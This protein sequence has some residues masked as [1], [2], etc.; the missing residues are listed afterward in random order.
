MQLIVNNQQVYLPE[1]I[2]VRIDF[3][4]PDIT[5]DS[6]PAAYIHWFEF[7]WTK[8]NIATF[9]NANHTY[10]KKN[11]K[12]QCIFRFGSFGFNGYLYL[13]NSFVETGKACITLFDDFI[14]ADKTFINQL[15]LGEYPIGDTPTAVLLHAKTENNK[16]WPNAD[17]CFPM[18]HIAD[19]YGQD[20]KNNLDYLGWINCYDATSQSFVTNLVNGLPTNR[21]ALVPCFYLFSALKKCFEAFGYNTFGEFFNILDFNKIAV[22]NNYALDKYQSNYIVKGEITPP[23]LIQG[24]TTNPETY[25]IL[26]GNTYFDGQWIT[27]PALGRYNISINFDYRFENTRPNQLMSI[28]IF[29]EGHPYYYDCSQFVENSSDTDDWISTSAQIWINVQSSIVGHRICFIYNFEL[30][31]PGD[32]W[33]NTNGYIQNLAFVVTNV[34]M[35]TYNALA[36]SIKMNNHLPAISF[37]ELIN[38]ICKMFFVV[39]FFDFDKKQVEFEVLDNIVDSPNFID[40]TEFYIANNESTEVKDK[41]FSFSIGNNYTKDEIKNVPS[42]NYIGAFNNMLVA[43]ASLSRAGDYCLIKSHDAYYTSIYDK[44]LNHL[45]WVFYSWATKMEGN[46]T[47]S[48][49][50]DISTLPQ[51]IGLETQIMPNIS[52]QGTSPAFNLVN[53]FPFALFYFYGLNIS[54]QASNLPA[55][56]SSI[57][58]NNGDRIGNVALRPNGTDG[59]F[60][61]N[62]KRWFTYLASAEEKTMKFRVDIDLFLKLAKIFKPQPGPNKTRKVRIGSKNYIPLEFHF[63]LG[64]DHIVESEAILI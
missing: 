14:N 59:L 23:T 34:S 52:Q 40:L 63:V 2:Q 29:V 12:Y 25:D 10:V 1:N 54:S 16:V 55:S 33:Y 3:L 7:P 51:E 20:K 5:G 24:T 57:Y 9:Q 37:A 47:V 46:G 61:A 11:R 13:K 6:I 19:F 39:P 43:Y 53:D 27:L 48:V 49:K 26:L 45:Q 50:S 64:F 36:P 56:S 32:P 35:S 42:E 44:N 31:K 15:E 22:F 21:N 4:F 18:M 8:E 28:S 17:Y 30:Q 62:A 41:S 38:S 58:D 60:A